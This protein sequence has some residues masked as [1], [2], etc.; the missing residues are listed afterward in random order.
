MKE[1]GIVITAVDL[2]GRVRALSLALWTFA[3]GSCL[4]PVRACID[5]QGLHRLLY[6]FHG[7][8]SPYT[9]FSGLATGGK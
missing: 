3:G 1:A 7:G 8:P 2:D 9:Y 5:R 4:G 6:L